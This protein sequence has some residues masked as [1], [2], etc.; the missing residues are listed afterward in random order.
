MTLRIALVAH[1]ALGGSGV[2]AIEWARLLAESGHDIT[3][4]RTGTGVR[5]PLLHPSGAL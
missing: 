2:M 4:F 3:L 5:E 1:H